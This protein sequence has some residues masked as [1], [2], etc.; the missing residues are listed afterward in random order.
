[1]H[2]LGAVFLIGIFDVRVA[3]VGFGG[4]SHR[5]GIIGVGGWRWGFEFDPQVFLIPNFHISLMQRWLVLA[6][7]SSR[8]HFRVE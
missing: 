1:M 3:T 4:L 8:S 6:G 2:F 5:A 7:R